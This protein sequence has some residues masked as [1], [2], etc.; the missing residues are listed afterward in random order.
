MATAAPPQPSVLDQ[1]LKDNPPAKWGVVVFGIVMV[2]GLIYIISKLAHDLSSVHQASVFPYVLLGTALL[3]ALGFEFVNGFHDTANA[4]ATVIYTHSLEPHIAVVWSGL[5]N[6]IGVLT[7]SGAVAFSIVA[8]LPV[9]LILKVSSGSGFAMVFALLVAAVIWNLATWWRGLPVSSSH[10]MVGSILGVGLAN[11]FI[12]GHTGTSGVDWA[13]VTKVFKALI[14]SPIIGFVLAAVVFFSSSSSP[15]IP[16]STRPPKAPSRRPSTSAPCSSSP[17]PA[18]PSPTA[19]T[20]ARRAWASSCS[21]SS[22]PSPPPTL[23]TTPST[24]APSF[25]FAAVSTEV[26]GAL[27]NYAD[28][29]ATVQDAAQGL[30]QF[31]SSHKLQPSTMTALQQMV[32]NIRNEAELRLAR[33]RPRRTCRPTSA[34]RCTSPAKPCAFCP[35]S[36]PR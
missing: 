22:A 33:Q 11:Q 20:T 28:K 36:A 31:V 2:A 7:S 19:P 14:F 18:S 15:R 12:N 29:S 23:S 13:Q 10:T 9:E 1:K 34:T 5:W 27:G 32:V 17:A 16:A 21:S 6:F 24:R 26:A 4:V 3:I 25:A 30:E 8:L 35:S